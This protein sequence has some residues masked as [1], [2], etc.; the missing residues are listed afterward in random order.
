MIRPINTSCRQAYDVTKTKATHDMPCC[1]NWGKPGEDDT[2]LSNALCNV[3][4]C[5]PASSWNSLPFGMCFSSL[6][7]FRK[8]ESVWV[9]QHIYFWV[10]HCKFLAWLINVNKT[11]KFKVP[12]YSV[13]MLKLWAFLMVRNGWQYL[14]K[15][16]QPWNATSRLLC[17]GEED[18]TALN[19]TRCY[20]LSD[21][22][23]T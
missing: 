22:K 11:W 5:C 8:K 18:D 17:V 19:R 23:Q 13:V 9:L 7:D 12:V 16:D 20:V 21:I 10:L 2:R 6:C 4:A 1:N 3:H 15:Y 14:R